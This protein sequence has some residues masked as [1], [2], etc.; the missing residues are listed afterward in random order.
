MIECAKFHQ[1]YDDFLY[2]DFRHGTSE[3]L[4]EGKERAGKWSIFVNGVK[5]ARIQF[6]DKQSSARGARMYAE[7]MTEGFERGR[8]SK[9]EYVKK[10][11]ASK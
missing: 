3:M 11:R 7:A 10:G 1:A 5:V 4:I 6:G 8:A 2:R 9:D